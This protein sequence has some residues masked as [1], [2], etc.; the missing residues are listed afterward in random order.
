M[1]QPVIYYICLKLIVHRCFRIRHYPRRIFRWRR[2]LAEQVL[3]TWRFRCLREAEKNVIW[4]QIAVHVAQVMKFFKSLDDLNSKGAR[5][6]IREFQFISFQDIDEWY[7]ETLHDE[8]VLAVNW[9]PV[10]YNNRQPLTIAF[11]FLLDRLQLLKYFMLICLVG[12]RVIFLLF[13]EH[14]D[15]NSPLFISIE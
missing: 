5:L 13:Y 10:V 9:H 15:R 2:S 7:T 14:F 1:G 6:L 11:I 3:A 4:F 8:K 12:I